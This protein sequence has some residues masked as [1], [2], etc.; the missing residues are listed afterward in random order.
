MDSN[1]HHHHR[2]HTIEE[3]D[4]EQSISPNFS[5]SETSM[6]EPPDPEPTLLLKE[7]EL[8]D[9]DAQD[10]NNSLP[11]TLSQVPLSLSKATNNNRSLA[12]SAKRPSKD[13]HTKVEGRG[14]RIRMPATC[15]ARIFQ[16]TRELGH[17]SDGETIR[18]LL[19]H[20]EPAII[21]ATGTGTVP[22][23]AVSINGTLKI[24]TT[25]PARPDGDE[26]LP[27][28][29][30][31][32]P[33]NS[34]FIDVNEHRQ[35][36]QQQQSSLSSGLAPISPTNTT[37][38]LQNNNFGSAQGL[39][40]FW[41]MGTF[42]LPQSAGLTGGV[43]VGGSNQQPQLWAIPA[44]ATPFFNVA[45]RPISNFVSAMQPGVQLG[46]GIGFNVSNTIGSSGLSTASPSSSS[47]PMGSMSSS[48]SNSGG[49]GGGGNTS[50]SGSA[51]ML[52]DF[53]LEIYDKKELQFLGQPNSQQT[54]CSKS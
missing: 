14:R 22:A 47:S 43:G 13:R 50:N 28:K 38:T 32:R 17:K 49:G 51:Q 6:V 19:E 25:S 7:E 53:S 44:N 11:I 18:W 46:A 40:P 2:H 35:H 45:A 41:P 48:T 31:K 27:R 36:Q 9:T 10:N 3:I 12:S 42:V 1:H 8:T 5:S 15:A 16:L 54:S 37:A 4:Q 21:E 52:R 39:V 29:R 24:P 20:A 23:I 34:E 33:S 26:T 30:R